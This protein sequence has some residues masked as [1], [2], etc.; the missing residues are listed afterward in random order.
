[1]NP[2]PSDIR[3]LLQDRAY[4]YEMLHMAFGGRPDRALF[5]ALSWPET[6]HCLEGFMEGSAAVETA[7]CAVSKLTE[8]DVMESVEALEREHTSMFVGPGKLLASPWEST[9][10]SQEALL[11]Q[12]NTLSVREAYRKQ[13]LQLLRLH[14][15]PDDHISLMCSYMVAISDGLS[16]SLDDSD[17]DSAGNTVI[18]A[19]GFI[20]QHMQDWLP[21]YVDRVRSIEDPVLYPQLVEVAADLV[22]RDRVF[23]ENV[24]VWLADIKL[25]RTQ[26]L[27]SDDEARGDTDTWLKRVELARGK[28]RSL[29]LFGIEDNLLVPITA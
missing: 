25:G 16:T 29:S 1:M 26:M 4:C 19:D 27:F 9:Y 11:F 8:G 6:S 14:K 24:L 12:E 28:I 5:E 21:E 18:Q 23:L 7:L 22:C 2:S 20:E 10:V 15:V 17:V 13:G 3:G